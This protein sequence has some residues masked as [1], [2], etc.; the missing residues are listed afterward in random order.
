[1]AGKP[2][3]QEF[4]VALKRAREES[5]MSLRELAEAV[6]ASHTVVAQ[7]ER[8]EHAPRPPRVRMLEHSLRL[9]PGTLA[10]HLGYWPIDNGDA[11]EPVSVLEAA[12]ADPRLSDRDRRVLRA[13]YRELVLKHDEDRDP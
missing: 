11:T 1:V 2:E 4:S 12:Q 3:L 9:R 6:E 8:A 10:R 13:V 5:G 7:W